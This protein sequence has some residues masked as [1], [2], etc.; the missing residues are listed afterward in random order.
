[1]RNPLLR[2]HPF[3][4]EDLSAY[5]D[6]RLSASESAR[7]EAHLT[8]CEACRRN[9]DGLRAVV[10]GLRGLPAVAAPRSFALRPEQ[11]EAPRRQ[12]PAGRV[13]R[14]QPTLAFG[15][16]GVAVAAL[17]LLVVLAGV[18]LGTSG[19]GGAPEGVQVTDRETFQAEAPA[20]GL[21][22][23]P[24]VVPAPAPRVGAGEE[25]EADASEATAEAAVPSETP[26]AATPP[27]VAEEEGG[28]GRQVLRGFEGAAGAAFIAAIAAL[29]WQ[30]RRGR[31]VGPT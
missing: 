11:V 29:V 19:G 21:A 30:R 5:L 24:T 23:A 3:G 13:A 26:L 18:D 20:Q 1:V 31:G 27:G 2:R 9:L 16:A 22:P 4:E 12:A 25:K 8:S 7:L 15:P 28:V 17:L 10:E 14:R 6:G